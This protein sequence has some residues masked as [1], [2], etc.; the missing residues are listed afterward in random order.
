PGWIP[1]IRNT[2]ANHSQYKNH[3][4]FHGSV[5]IAAIRLSH[6]PNPRDPSI[7]SAAA[8]VSPPR[9]LCGLA[10][11]LSLGGT[12][13]AATLAELNGVQAVTITAD[14][15][16]RRP[17][18]PGIYEAAYSPATNALYVAS[19]EAITGVSG[20]VIYQI[21]PDTLQTQ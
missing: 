9:L 6:P 3:H 5:Q 16:T 14:G 10:L 18:A 17:I 2:N 1:T 21:D 12:S 8:H 13:H 11:A 20:G 4:R 19:A 15:A 7:M